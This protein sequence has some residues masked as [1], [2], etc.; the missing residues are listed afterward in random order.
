MVKRL[1]GT[2]LQFW[3]GMR[4][5]APE[6]W[7][8]EATA[9][10][11]AGLRIIILQWIQADGKNLYEPPDPFPQLLDIAHQQKMQVVFGLRHDSR[12]W[13]EWGNAEYL[14]AEA[15][16]SIAVARAV[17]RLYGKHP[18]FA[19]F[20]IP[21]EIWDGSFTKAQVAQMTQFLRTVGY[22]CRQ[23]AP[24]KPVFVAPFFAGLLPP[25]RFEQLWL[26][27]LKDKPVDVVALQD[28]VG[29]RG[30]DEEIEK[31]VPPYFAAMQKACRQRGVKLWC[32]LECF[33]LTNNV[34][35]RPAFAPASAERIVRQLKA[36]SPYVERVVT[37]DFYHYMSPYRGEAQRALYE[38]YLR[39]VM[40]ESGKGR[41]EA[42]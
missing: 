19:G 4:D 15:R 24:S 6:Q 2:F 17:H 22:A 23:I 33:R 11:T 14:L 35:S 3:W 37:F 27:L 25:E 7:E 18:V 5:V 34:P 26:A 28:G 36:V 9:M 1:E 42:G 39:L 31:R 30:W 10:Q 16:E 20:Y 8:R 13:R 38:G 41:E 32:D 12:W 29:A 21:Y 40:H